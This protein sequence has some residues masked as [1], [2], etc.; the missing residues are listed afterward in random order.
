MRSEQD[1]RDLIDPHSASMIFHSSRSPPDG[2]HHRCL[3]L[4]RASLAVA[5]TNWSHEAV[6]AVI[7]TRMVGLKR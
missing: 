6:M 3:R 7:K 4:F 2:C 1:Y 5:T